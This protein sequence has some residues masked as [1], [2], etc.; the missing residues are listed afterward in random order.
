M[1]TNRFTWCLVIC[2]AAF[3]V[4][5][6]A[7]QDDI[8][9][10]P[11]AYSTTEPHN[12]V[13]ELEQQIA[14][15]KQSLVREE[16]Y[17]YLRSLLAALGIPVE[18]QVLVF[19]KTSLQVQRISPRTPRAIYFADDVY[20]GFCQQGEVI[21]V[22]VADPKL[23]TAFYTLDQ[24]A[25]QPEF[26]RQT[27]TCLLC[28]SSS[29]TEGVPGHLVR[30]LYADAGGQPVYS[31]GSL[32]VTHSTP[33]AERW[34]GWYVTG[35]HGKQRHRGNYFAPRNLRPGDADHSIGQNVTSLDEYFPTDKYL[36]PHSDLVALMVLEHQV[37]VHNRLTSANYVARQALAYQDMMNDYMDQP[38]GTPLDSTTRR[39]ATA[40]DKLVEALLFV[41]EAPLT[42]AL[43]G[44]AGYAEQ[45]AQQ[46]ERDPQGRSLRDF[47]LQTRMFKH[48]CSY[49]IDSPAFAD[50]PPAMREYVWQKVDDVLAGRDTSGRFDHLASADRVAIR[51]IVRATVAGVPAGW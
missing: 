21:E 3:A 27:D 30:S 16:H 23:G 15:G 20:V 24:Q 13:S 50:L 28:H 39:I 11:I 5:W 8:E 14:S 38:D 40:G 4:P 17:G 10:P 1:L 37:L 46:G 7:A 49:L 51:E 34:G 19:S 12:R 25:P 35:E 33:F 48:P 29:R 22:S 41:D 2:A 32:N 18:S 47:D 31:A 44:P 26:T 42:D 45:F 6:A 43:K 36:T 9:Q